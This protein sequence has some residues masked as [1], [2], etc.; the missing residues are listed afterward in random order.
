MNQQTYYSMYDLMGNNP[1]YMYE[2]TISHDAPGGGGAGNITTILANDIN[3]DN[4]SK[5]FPCAVALILNKLLKDGVY[6]NLVQPFTTSQKPDLV[7]QSGSHD[8]GTKQ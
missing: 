8:L 2:Y 5:A 1:S 3:T 7:W 4:L 6:S